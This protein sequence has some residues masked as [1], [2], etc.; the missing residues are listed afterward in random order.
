MQMILKGVEHLHKHWILH[1]DLKPD[2]ILINSQ[3][4]SANTTPSFLLK[5]DDD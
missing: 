5:R 1:R 3:V 4:R 2:N